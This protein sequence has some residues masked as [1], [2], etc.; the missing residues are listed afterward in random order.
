MHPSF[1]ED[2]LAR[3]EEIPIFFASSTSSSTIDL[4]IPTPL[5]SGS[6]NI[7]ILRG[8]P[9]E[10]RVAYELLFIVHA[11]EAASKSS[12]IL[13]FIEPGF[14]FLFWEMAPRIH[15]Q[16]QGS[17]PLS[18]IQNPVGHHLV[19]TPYRPVDFH[20]RFASCISQRSNRP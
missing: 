2:M 1:R 12:L 8:S 15:H 10:D 3:I 20:P 11:A 5:N 4:P 13:I 6:M 9:H 18:L 19:Q 16:L 7:D 17:T 14:N